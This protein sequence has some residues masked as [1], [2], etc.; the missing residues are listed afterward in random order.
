MTVFRR[1]E[2]VQLDVPLSKA[3]SL[4]QASRAATYLALS[5]RPPLTPGATIRLHARVPE[6]LGTEA[7]F[8]AALA[9]HAP[10]W[11]SLLSGPPP[12]G[13]GAQRAVMLALL[14]SRY[15]LEGLGMRDPA[16]LRGR[17]EA[18]SKPPPPSGPAT[19]RVPD[20]FTALPQLGGAARPTSG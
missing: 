3:S 11:T 13:A 8:R 14:G 5:P 7:G 18:W 10:T 9:R 15:H 4:Y 12:T 19:L 2:S 1:F 16:P 20:P 17:I 6:G